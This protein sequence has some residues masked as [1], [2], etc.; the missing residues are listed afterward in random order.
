[1]IDVPAT[2][3]DGVWQDVLIPAAYLNPGDVSLMLYVD[4]PGFLLNTLGFTRTAQPTAIYPATRAL[5]T[6]VAE[7]ENGG[8][9]AGRGAIR[10][11]GRQGTSLTWGVVA[12]QAGGATLRFL[13]QNN[14][15][16]PLPFELKSGETPAQAMAL[17]PTGSGWKDFDVK[18]SLQAG[19]NRVQFSGLVDGWDSITLEQLELVMP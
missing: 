17:P 16:K 18:V 5:R 6:G 15:G 10:N 11:F 4:Q 7:I 12:P 9:S 1:V 14:N 2:G 19:A 3:G 8:G 13:Y